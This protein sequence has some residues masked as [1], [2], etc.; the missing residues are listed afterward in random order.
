[1]G[2]IV[3]QINLAFRDFVTEGVASSGLH[4]VDKRDVRAIG[5]MLEAAIAATSLGTMVDVIKTTRTLLEADLAW[6][7]NTVALVYADANDS[8]N[9]LYVKSGASGS[10]SWTLTSALHGVLLSAGA[11]A[12]INAVPFASWSELAAASGGAGDRAS[13]IAADLGTHTDPVIGGTV[14]NAG[15]YQWSVSPAGWERIGDLD[16]QTAAAV[17]SAV[18]AIQAELASLIFLTPGSADVLANFV[19]Q[20][21]NLLAQVLTNQAAWR[22]VLES[23]KTS[24]GM[25]LTLV[26]VT[27]AADAGVYFIDE[28][29][30]VI[31]RQLASGDASAEVVTA[32][33]SRSALGDRIGNGLT[34][35]GSPRGEFV[36]IERMYEMRTRLGLLAAGKVAQLDIGILGDSQHDSGGF[37]AAKDFADQLIADY[38]DA[39]WGFTGDVNISDAN[40]A[41]TPQP[42]ADV[43]KQIAVTYNGDWSQEYVEVSARFPSSVA[44]PDTPDMCG[45]QSASAGRMVSHANLTAGAPLSDAIWIYTDTADGQ[46]EYR[47]GTYNSGT[48][49]NAASY[50]FGSWTSV[51]M[52]V[53]SGTVKGASLTT[54]MPTSGLWMLQ[55]RVVSGTVRSCG[56]NYK[57]AQS[58]V[59]VH[60][61]ATSASRTADVAARDATKWK[62]GIA[63]FGI[64]AWLIAHM[65]NESSTGR[66]P[67]QFSTSATTVLT[68]VRAVNPVCDV[69]WV[70]AFENK[71]DA[72]HGMAAKPAPMS[73]Y[74]AL[75]EALM[76]ANKGALIDLQYTAGDVAD[77]GA[78]SKW[79]ASFSGTI[80]TVTGSNLYG[81]FPIAVGQYVWADSD[82]QPGGAQITALG[83]GTG[84]AGT[85]TLDTNVGTLTSRVVALSTGRRCLM[86]DPIHPSQRRGR[87]A[88]SGAYSRAFNPKKG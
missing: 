39:G 15:L 27:S 16:S 44:A 68:N 79:L 66:T 63:L 76:A 30:N 57:S 78:D 70:G 41:T 69:C 85:Y 51:A 72:A 2:N 40:Y 75:A 23:I 50:T 18:D 49:G 21:D 17:K 58:G 46:A 28:N 35:Y 8:N 24:D 25:Q 86:A 67:A 10:G 88:I 11:R 33:G 83:T 84:G 22:L 65:T 47:W 52:N 36:G 34:A 14:S 62:A 37:N 42:R 20:E 48:I 60:N 31:A 53:A 6:G 81:T 64:N 56:M 26:P 1:M 55:R 7:P 12:A 19:D 73:D 82:D 80:M 32:R 87:A 13:V 4:D 61:F 29:D 38:G 43:R 3:D 71:N 74:T 5:P 77:Y 54:G 59:R 45:I 9:D